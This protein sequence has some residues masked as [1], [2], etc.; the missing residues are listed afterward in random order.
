MPNKRLTINTFIEKSLLN[1][2]YIHGEVLEETSEYIKW[3]CD[4]NPSYIIEIPKQDIIPYSDNCIRLSAR[5]YE[6]LKKKV[7]G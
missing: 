7:K 2:A 3:S 6:K 1:G 5:F 4:E